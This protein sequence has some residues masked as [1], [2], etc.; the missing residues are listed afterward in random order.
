[1]SSEIVG[2]INQLLQSWPRGTVALQPFF[3]RH[4]VS[5][6]LAARYRTS[7]WIDPVG[8]GAFVRRGDKV[9]WEGAVYALQRYAGKAIQ[10]GGRTALELHGYAHFLRMGSRREVHLFGP[11]SERLPRWILYHDWGADLRYFGTTLFSRAVGAGK[12]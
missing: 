7:G 12:N 8:R 9:G 1:M 11:P 5:Q 3:S 4:G 6:K 2:K 10:P